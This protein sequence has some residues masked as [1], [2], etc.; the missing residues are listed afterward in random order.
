MNRI[1][2]SRRVGNSGWT[3][4]RSAD[5][6]DDDDDEDDGDRA[7]GFGN[8]IIPPRVSNRTRRVSVL[9]L[10]AVLPAGC[11][12][13]S[14]VRA[15]SSPHHGELTDT[16]ERAGPGRRCILNFCD[17]E[18]VTLKAAASR[19]ESTAQFLGRDERQRDCNLE[20]TRRKERSR[21]LSMTGCEVF[22]G[23]L[24]CARSH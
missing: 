22:S 14:D 16:V 2:V 11:A 10:S 13:T 12:Q 5:D 23:V 24:R 7:V 15:N 17:Q 4:Q 6:D 19:R 1:K 18:S 3:P 9:R 8:A 21:P 20:R